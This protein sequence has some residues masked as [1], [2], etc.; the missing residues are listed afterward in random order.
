MCIVISLLK[1]VACTELSFQL[2]PRSTMV[3]AVAEAYVLITTATVLQAE[4]LQLHGRHTVVTVSSFC[5]TQLCHGS[6]TDEERIGRAL[7]LTRPGNSFTQS[8]GVASILDLGT[9]MLP[10]HNGVH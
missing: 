1:L 5:I 6:F 9:V 10:A 8:L 4:D 3:S 7:S 2:M